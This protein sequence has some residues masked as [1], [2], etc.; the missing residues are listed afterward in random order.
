MFPK[1]IP[2]GVAV[3][4]DDIHHCLGAVRWLRGI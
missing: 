1:F 4:A 3:F 2:K